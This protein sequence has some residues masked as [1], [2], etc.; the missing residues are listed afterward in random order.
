MAIKVIT[1]LDVKPPNVVKPI[2][3]E[4]LR[5]KKRYLQRANE[6]F[7]IE[8]SRF[9]SA[10]AKDPSPR[11]D[12]TQIGYNYRMSNILAG[13]GRGQLKVLDDRAG[14]RRKIFQYY[15]AE[16]NQIN[17]IEWMPEPNKYYS[18]RWLSVFIINPSKTNITNNKLIEFLS[19]LNI[20][21]LHVWKPMHQQAAFRWLQYFTKGEGS[22][23][24]YLFDNGA[25]L[26]SSLNMK[27]E[28]QDLVIRGILGFF[29][30]E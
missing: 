8:K 9:L 24:Y 12:H 2:H 3:F 23:C 6:V 14:A 18:N 21:A 20:E 22:Y 15:K 27:I 28:Q 7:Y 19:K 26:P 13:A 30:N 4:G 29:H 17:A 16:L 11:Y 10:Q 25:F 1:K 5:A